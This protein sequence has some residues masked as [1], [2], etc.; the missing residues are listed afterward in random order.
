[1]EMEELRMLLENVEDSYSD[2]VSG[3]EAYVH[4][5]PNEIKEIKSFIRKNPEATSSDILGRICSRPAFWEMR[6]R[7]K[8]RKEGMYILLFQM[9]VEDYDV[10]ARTGL[11]GNVSEIKRLCKKTNVT[12]EEFDDINGI[13]YYM[14][15]WNIMADVPKMANYKEI[16]SKT[17]TVLYE[18]VRKKRLLEVLEDNTIKYLAEAV[19]YV[20][21]DDLTQLEGY[22]YEENAKMKAREE[23]I[24][25]LTEAE[26][27][28]AEGRVGLVSETFDDLRGHLENVTKGENHE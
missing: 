18:C 21:H 1:M 24:T 2:F 14:S 17:R 25:L 23:I 22:G 27:D 5:R 10:V 4:E 28:V 26:R 12:E 3:V 15:Y 9:L 6:Y 16:D 8:W 19:K 20:F 11:L 13:C 7:E